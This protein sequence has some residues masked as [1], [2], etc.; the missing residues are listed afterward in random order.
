MCPRQEDRRKTEPPLWSI[1]LVVAFMLI[2]PLVLYSMAPADPMREGGTIF[3]DGALKVPLAHP[4]LYESTGFDGTCLL[5][6]MIHSWCFDNQ[7][8]E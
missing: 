6:P 4:R 1:G 7:R 5:D 3:T 2:V 8:P